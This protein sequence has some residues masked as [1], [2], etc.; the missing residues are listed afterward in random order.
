[1]YLFK[2][3]M[4]GAVSFFLFSFALEWVLHCGDLWISFDAALPPILGAVNDEGSAA[5]APRP[6]CHGAAGAAAPEGAEKGQEGR[7]EGTRETGN[8]L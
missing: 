8:V 3:A 4:P 7:N 2:A 5:A 6:L 1:L